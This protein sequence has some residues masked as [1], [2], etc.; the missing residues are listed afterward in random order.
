MESILNYHKL[1]NTYPQI[2]NSKVYVKQIRF[3]ISKRLTPIPCM[4]ET[5][6]LIYLL[7][8]SKFH[9]SLHQRRSVEKENSNMRTITISH[10]WFRK[11]CKV[12]LGGD[13]IDHTVQTFMSD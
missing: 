9:S 4:I 10:N 13:L 12:K 7:K 6:E 1:I 3:L 11:T 2:L 5:K 8:K